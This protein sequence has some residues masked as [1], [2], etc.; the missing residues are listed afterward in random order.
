MAAGEVR[1]FAVVGVCAIPATAHGVALNVTATLSSDPGFFV[2]YPGGTA[3]PG[4]STLNYH[5][6]QTRANNVV[7]GLGPSG[8]ILVYCNQTVGT[9]HVVIDVNGWFE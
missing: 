3:T 1:S 5:A 8:D 4:T 9:A 7:V 2:V 6:G